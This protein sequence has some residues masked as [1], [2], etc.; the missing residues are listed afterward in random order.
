MMS[1]RFSSSSA[2]VQS[3]EMEMPRSLTT[4]V[5]SP[6]TT[7][8]SNSGVE[9]MRLAVTRASTAPVKAIIEKCSRSTKD[10]RLMVGVS[11]ARLALSRCARFLLFRTLSKEALMSSPQGAERPRHVI[12]D[13]R[14]RTHGLWI[15]GPRV[16]HPE[17]QGSFPGA[18]FQTL[19]W[20][21]RRNWPG[22]TSN[23]SRKQRLK[24]GSVAKPLAT[25]IS[26]RDLLVC[27]S[28]WR[29]WVRRSSM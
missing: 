14:E 12:D 6:P 16:F 24:C 5:S 7:R 11:P 28:N 20:L 1:W 4:R 27:C 23:F 26:V 15:Q 22:A 3:V 13:R 9:L 8:T 19:K 21:R 29:A 17:I 25:A 2:R 18:T 10:T